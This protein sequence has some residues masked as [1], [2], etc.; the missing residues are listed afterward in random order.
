MKDKLHI[1]INAESKTHS[2]V[3]AKMRKH[4][5]IVDEPDSFGGKDLGPNPIEYVF[6]GLAGCLNVTAHKV[7]SEK[8][9]EIKKLNF[10]ISGDLDIERFM[11]KDSKKRA[12]F[13]EI[14]VEVEIETDASEAVE[15]EI[16]H[17]AEK[18]CPISDNLQHK[19]NFIL[20]ILTKDI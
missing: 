19:T 15:K 9:V 11:N 3:D 2:R 5:S 4:E 20:N 7:A 10:K 8:G 1:E 6:T 13:D 16:L 17:E 14:K 18:R 12:G